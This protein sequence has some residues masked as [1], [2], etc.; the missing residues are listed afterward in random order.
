MSPSR[1]L[2][3]FAAAA[4]LWSPAAY[5]ETTTDSAT[6]RF[7]QTLR[8]H[9]D[10]AY[11][12]TVE[13]NEP[14]NPDDA[15]V[16]NRLRIHLRGCTAT[17]VAIPL[18][19]G[20][21]RS[22]T[23]VISQTDTGLRLKHDHRHEDGSPDAVTLY[24]GD[25]AD[26]STAQRVH[27]PVDAESVALFEREGLAASVSNVWALEISDTQLVYELSRPGRLFRAVFDLTQPIDPPPA[28]WGH[29]D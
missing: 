9:C 21:D 6:A 7:M 19:V 4:C 3:L 20:D 16:R 10:K 2:C 5:T 14:A 29:S 13:R 22:R 17:Q 23:W 27:F 26:D 1:L 8:T 24:G 15:F 28:P 25:S 11:A 12:G 18:H